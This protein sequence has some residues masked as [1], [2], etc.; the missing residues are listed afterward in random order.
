MA[1]DQ[2]Q[3]EGDRQPKSGPAST[4]N[5]Y[6]K[7]MLL[8]LITLS[9]PRSKYRVLIF[10][11]DMALGDADSTL[12][13]PRIMGSILLP[14]PERT[15]IGGSIEIPRIINGLWQ[16]AGGHDKNIQIASASKA[17]DYL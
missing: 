7:A 8:I 4:T 10:F 12:Q 5:L 11:K 9:T 6:Y 2:G 14:I 1:R 13:S 17:M 3:S 15:L 16:L